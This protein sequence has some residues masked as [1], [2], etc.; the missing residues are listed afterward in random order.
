MFKCLKKKPPKYTICILNVLCRTIRHCVSLLERM[1]SKKLSI[2]YFFQNA[3]DCSLSRDGRSILL[4]IKPMKLLEHTQ[5]V[6]NLQELIVGN[7][8]EN[9]SVSKHTAGDRTTKAFS[10]CLDLRG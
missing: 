1:S 8:R 7:E 2:Y 4:T 5:R 9:C 6:N 10:L 3:V